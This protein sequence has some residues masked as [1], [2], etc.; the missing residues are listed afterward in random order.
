[1]CYLYIKCDSGEPLF[2]ESKP[3]NG[4]GVESWHLSPLHASIF[5]NDDIAVVHACNYHP[6][7]SSA[8][9]VMSDDEA[10]NYL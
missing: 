8:L 2:L 1:M 6:D 4:G 3:Y 10:R 9:E 7:I 5:N